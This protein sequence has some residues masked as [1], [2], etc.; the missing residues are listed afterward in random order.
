LSSLVAAAVGCGNNDGGKTSADAFSGD[1]H[2]V[3]S[4]TPDRGS[5]QYYSVVLHRRPGRSGP[6]R[7]AHLRVDRAPVL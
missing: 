6:S 1:W 4:W 5:T 2:G 7:A 3:L